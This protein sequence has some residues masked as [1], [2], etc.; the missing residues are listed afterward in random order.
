MPQENQ[1][2]RFRSARSA[3]RIDGPGPC[4]SPRC[5]R[6]LRTVRGKAYL[7]DSHSHPKTMV[8]ATDNDAPS[9]EQHFASW[10]PRF[11]YRAHDAAHSRSTAIHDPVW[12]RTLC[13]V[14]LFQSHRPIVLQVYNGLVRCSCHRLCCRLCSSRLPLAQD[15]FRTQSILLAREQTRPFALFF[16]ALSSAH[17]PCRCFVELCLTSCATCRCS[18]QRNR[19]MLPSRRWTR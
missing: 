14:F 18:F 12:L 16:S 4:T 7:L 11:L 19:D 13:P 6:V 5:A 8:N 15:I 2:I 3:P 17:R 1:L 10:T 9:G